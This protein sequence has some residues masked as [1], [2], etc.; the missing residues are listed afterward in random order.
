MPQP[1]RDYMDARMWSEHHLMWHSV[2]QWDLVSASDQQTMTA[3]GWHRAG[4]QEGSVGNGMD[5]LAMHR[6]MLDEL[7]VA[8]PAQ[9]QLFVGWATPPTDPHDTDNPVPHPAPM[10]A[11]VTQAIAKLMSDGTLALPAS[12]D[13]L[14]LYI[15]TP[16]RPLPGDPRHRSPDPTTGVHNSLHGRFATDDLNDPL[17]MG[18]PGR[19]LNNQLFWRLH[20]W[21]DNRWSQYR[22][23]KG[24][25]D[26]DPDYVAAIQAAK[27]DMQMHHQHMNALMLGADQAKR[28]V[29]VRKLGHR[30][31]TRLLGSS[32]R[33]AG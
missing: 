15:E 19:N 25:T 16:L 11:N 23:L 33:P 18:D 17:D 27:D 12:Q 30:F 7:R 28:V 24:Q 14:G 5:F 9:A 4:R 20:G 8:F 6:V 2:R 22:H 3:A 26:A 21:I 1:I 13:L 32:E 10:P 29:D 31:F